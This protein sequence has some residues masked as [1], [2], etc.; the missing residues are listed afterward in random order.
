MRFSI[1][2]QVNK[3]SEIKWAECLARGRFSSSGINDINPQ[4]TLDWTR[5]VTQIVRKRIKYLMALDTPSMDIR[6]RR[7]LVSVG[8]EIVTSKKWI[9][10]KR[11]YCRKRKYGSYRKY[12]YYP[13]RRCCRKRKH[14]TY[15]KIL[16]ETE[17]LSESEILPETEIFSESEI[18]PESENNSGNGNI[19]YLFETEI[20]S[21]IGNIKYCS[22]RK[23]IPESENLIGSASYE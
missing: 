21:G 4:L 17:I 20:N 15:R 12:K 1:N 14:G 5:R 8:A 6:N 7:I 13:S 18:L 23:W 2:Q 9:L 19:K 22:Y 10:R 16:S 11:W 3:F